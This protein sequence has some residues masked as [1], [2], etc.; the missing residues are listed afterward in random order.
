MELPVLSE[1][2]EKDGGCPSLDPGAPGGE[3]PLLPGWDKR[4]LGETF[5]GT[6][7]KVKCQSKVGTK[8]NN[9]YH[10]LGLGSVKTLH[11]CSH[12]EALTQL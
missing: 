4:S 2:G 9:C 12:M 6:N 11:T 8:K 5:Q 7:V 3:K 1:V 10:L